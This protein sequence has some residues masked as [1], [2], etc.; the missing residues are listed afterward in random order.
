MNLKFV[1]A[2]AASLALLGNATGAMASLYDEDDAT[3]RAN[4]FVGYSCAINVPSYNLTLPAQVGDSEATGSRSGAFTVSQN[5]D[6]EWSLTQ[7]TA[8][9]EPSPIGTGEITLEFGG[10]ELAADLSTGASEGVEGHL[11]N[12][13]VDMSATIGTVSDAFYGGETYEIESVLTCVF[14]G[15]PTGPTLDNDPDSGN[16]Y[17]GGCNA[18]RGNGS[19]PDENGEDCDP[20]NSGGNNNGGD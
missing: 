12:E 7:V 6:T 9:M 1:A 19:E 3:I 5:G 2:A 20:G 18:G 17:G 11:T 10:I 13:N 16:P 15:D 14:N 8:S 4:T